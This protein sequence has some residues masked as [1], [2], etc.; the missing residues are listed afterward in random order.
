MGHQGETAL[1]SRLHR[2]LD[3]IMMAAMLK[4]MIAQEMQQRPLQHSLAFVRAVIKKYNTKI[5]LK[6]EL[7]IA[8][9]AEQRTKHLVSETHTPPE[10]FRRL[11]QAWK[12]EVLVSAHGQ[13]HIIYTYQYGLSSKSC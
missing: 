6:A 8:G 3:P 12:L 2:P 13:T 1:N 11:Q 5:G 9:K 4:G 10:H 7:R